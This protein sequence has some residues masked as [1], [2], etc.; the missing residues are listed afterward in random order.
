MKKILLSFLSVLLVSSCVTPTMVRPRASQQVVSQERQRQYEMAVQN[1]IE[2]KERLYKIGYPILQSNADLC[3]RRGFRGKSDGILLYT[4][5]FFEPQM[6]S[7]ARE[8]LNISDGEFIVTHVFK[9]SN[10]EEVGIQFGVKLLGV[11]G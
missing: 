3:E 4:P 1:M 7:A 5:R 6:Q 2:Q 9:N 8:V 10:A 11:N